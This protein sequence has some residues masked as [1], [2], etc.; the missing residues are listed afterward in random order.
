[1]IPIQVAAIALYSTYTLCIL[2][3]NMIYVITAKL[4][5]SY[6][7]FKV[8]SSKE[9]PKCAWWLVPDTILFNRNYDTAH[10]SR[11]HLLGMEIIGLYFAAFLNQQTRL[12]TSYLVKY[13]NVRV[14]QTITIISTDVV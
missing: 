3:G 2:G 4:W 12:Y 10:N 14:P 11:E 7:G 13:Y 6:P 5:F 9:P 1:M 8:A